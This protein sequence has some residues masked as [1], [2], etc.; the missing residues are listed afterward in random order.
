MAKITG[1]VVIININ[2]K[3]VKTGFFISSPPLRFPL[4][5][6]WSLLTPGS[7]AMKHFKTITRILRV[8]QIVAAVI[9]AC[10]LFKAMKILL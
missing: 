1:P 2:K 10:F 9:L 6:L 3:P 4:Y 5:F 8:L 7:C